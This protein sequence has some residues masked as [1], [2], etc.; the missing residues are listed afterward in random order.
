MIADLEAAGY[1]AQMGARP[2]G[3]VVCFTCHRQ[4]DAADMEV[5]VLERTEG[6]SDPDDMLAVAALTC[7]NCGARGT[8][9]LSYGPE[10]D[11]DDAEVL[12]RLR[13][14]GED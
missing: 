9:V 2:D 1:R 10:S 11:Q 6:P 13:V 7:P 4:S 5:A 3:C 12:V 14:D 8:L